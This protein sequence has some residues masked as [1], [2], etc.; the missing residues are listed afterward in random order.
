MASYAELLVMLARKESLD[1]S[2][3]GDPPVSVCLG[4]N[5]VIELTNAGRLSTAEARIL[6]ESIWPMRFRRHP[7]D[8]D[9]SRWAP[10]TRR[11]VEPTL[12]SVRPVP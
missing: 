10:S 3:Y 11:E 6:V 8:P 12:S 4:I 1:D 9:L 5:L 7:A 2:D